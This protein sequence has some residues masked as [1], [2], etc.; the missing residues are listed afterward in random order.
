MSPHFLAF[1]I[2][3]SGVKAVVVDADGALLDS[4]Y[5]GY[6]I[7]TVND[8]VDQ[9]LDL[10]ISSALDAAEEL[11]GRVR[12]NHGA[13][14]S[15]EGISVTAQMFNL[16]AVD[17]SGKPLLPMISWLDQRAEGAARALAEIVPPSTQ[18][19]RFSAVLSAKDILPKILWLRNNR[20]EVYASTA[21]LL[22]CKEAVVLYLTGEAVTDHAGASAYRLYAH[23]SRGWD[24]GA[25]EAAGID[26]DK[27]PAVRNAT[28]VAGPLVPDVARRLGL[29]ADTPVYVGVG[30]V[31]ASQLGSG[32]VDPGDLHV[33]LGTAVYFGLMMSERRVDPRHRLGP[34]AHADAQ[35]WILW[36]EI[37]TGGAA[38][39]WALRMLGL[40]EPG[41]VDYTRVERMV[42]DSADDMDGLLFAPWLSGER[43]PVFDDA[44]R[45]SFI[46]LGLH[47][48]PGH[49]LRAVM[50]GVAFQMRWALQYGLEYGEDVKRI[51][52]VGGGSMGSVWMQIIADVLERPLEVIAEPQDAGAIGAA[53]CAI[54]GRGAKPNY[55]FLAGR[56]T[57]TRRYLPHPDRSLEYCAR[58]AQ[59][60]RLYDALY[61]IYHQ[62]GNEARL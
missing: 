24:R 17:E 22:D 27:L 30:D 40:G 60:Q 10:I 46:G 16:V 33:S 49:I 7:Q 19:K 28:D 4:A 18:F 8:A 20:P 48:T 43:V 41:S 55:S 45:A 56:A 50:E 32:A 37:A 3:T 15:I 23:H 12:S 6:G 14:V 35:R 57:V 34:L 62:T 54:V 11:L 47:H 29:P 5:R 31:P 9:D 52:A 1:D 51:R 42:E 21:K 53:A 61:P 13:S 25:C 39:T 59:Y 36:L 2:G 26:P 58:Y 38:L 44:A